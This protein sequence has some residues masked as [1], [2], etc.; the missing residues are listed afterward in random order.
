[1][2]LADPASRR[3][4]PTKPRGAKVLMILGAVLFVVGLVTG[5]QGTHR[6]TGAA[7]DISNSGD[8]IRNSLLAEVPVP[9]EADVELD[10][11]RYDVFA[12]SPEG[13]GFQ[14]TTT[15]T[16]PA[17]IP[18][19]RTDPDDPYPGY[20]EPTVEVTGPDG[21]AVLLRNPGIE[22]MFSAA[23]GELYPIRSFTVRQA[24]T[25][26]LT[27]SGSG[28]AQV[29]VGPTVDNGNFGRLVKSGILTALGYLGAGLGFVLA[30]AGVIWFA[31][32]GDRRPLAAPGAWPPP[33]GGWGPPRAPGPWG[34]PPPGPWG[35]PPP[36]W[37]A[38]PA[39]PWGAPGWAPPG[40]GAPG[41]PT[42]PVPPPGAPPP[43][44][45]PPAGPPGG[46]A[47]PAGAAG[48]PDAPTFV[49][50]PTAPWG[51]A[52]PTMPQAPTWPPTPDDR[53]PTGR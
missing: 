17:T 2:T 38:P 22:S 23:N 13:T 34:A 14:R 18:T 45:P 40:T 53:P 42:P 21:T 52:P 6:V 51:D 5:Q 15:S 32:A 36:T 9:G 19:D 39:G 8:E 24:G 33:P 11:G 1:M 10:R 3:D 25:Y 41:W 49:P 47:S 37:G 20:D 12:I 44:P 27:A 31:V 46:P 50:P 28:A 7:R 48:S 16:D 43:P 26:H 35:G 30:V 29:G 4:K